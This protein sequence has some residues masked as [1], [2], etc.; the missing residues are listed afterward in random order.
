MVEAQPG[1]GADGVLPSATA[2]R[3]PR[4][5]PCQRRAARW[6]P[7][8][9]LSS[10]ERQ[11]AA[12]AQHRVPGQAYPQVPV[13]AG[14]SRALLDVLVHMNDALRN[15]L[16]VGVVTVVLLPLGALAS[17]LIYFVTLIPSNSVDFGARMAN[18][19]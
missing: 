13:P 4:A 2:R 11:A 18:Q 16:P 5:D 1:I 3:R 19:S 6:Q 10:P 12:V 17:R 8:R 15:V 9:P 14:I 7:A